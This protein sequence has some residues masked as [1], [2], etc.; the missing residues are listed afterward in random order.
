MDKK[1][2]IKSKPFLSEINIDITE[3][4]KTL[5]EKGK[6][7]ERQW[8]NVYRPNKSETPHLP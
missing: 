4:Q 8:R 5:R 7:F 2:T 6:E 3:A 1:E